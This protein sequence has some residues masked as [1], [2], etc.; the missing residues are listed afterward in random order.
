M[1]CA[2]RAARPLGVLARWR[3]SRIWPFRL[4][5]TLSITSRVDASVRSLCTLA[6]VRCA[7]GSKQAGAAG[8]E[9][10]AVA[11]APEPL[12][13]NHNRSR[14]AGE[15]VG[16]MLARR[17]VLLREAFAAHRGEEIDTQCDVFFVAFGVLPMR[18]RQ[19]LCPTSLAEPER[20][21]GA[22][23]RVRI[24]IHSP[25]GRVHPVR[26][27]SSDDYR[28][29]IRLICLGTCSVEGR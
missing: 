12:V 6:A 2:I 3:S 29:T 24:G 27:P 1:R 11:A 10:F 13:G 4:A 14:V 23:V 7:V 8:S 15:Q 28:V 19:P 18:S 5:K 26:S 16:E 9:P 25:E 21:D 22:A 20:P 17:L